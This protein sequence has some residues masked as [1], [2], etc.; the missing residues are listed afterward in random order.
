MTENIVHLVLARTPDA[1]EGVKG[2]SLFIVPKFLPR[3]DGTPG[4]RNDIKCVSIEHKLGIHGSPTC[5]LAYGD[6]KGAIGYLVGEENRGLEYMF[7]MMNHARLSVGV[8]GVAVGERAYQHA[9]EYAKTRVQ[10]R[11]I[12][13]KSGDRVT[14]IHHPDVRRMLMSMRSQT[15]AMRALSYFAAATLDKAKHHPDPAER[16]RNQGLLDL[17]TPIVKGWCTEQGVDVASTG[18]QVHGGMGFIEETG[19][20]Q[21]LRDARITTIYEGT[22]GIQAGDL[23]GR[24]VGYEKGATALA[25]IHAMRALDPK[26][27]AGGEGLASIRS[28]L[29]ES[30]DGLEAAT[31]WIVETFPKDPKAVAGVSVPYL[32]LFGTVAGGW[33]MARAALV[34]NEKIKQPD[35]DQDFLNGKLATT[36]FYAEHEL[37]KAIPHAQEVLRGSASVLAL[38]P[39]KF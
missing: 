23:V 29:K 21:Y 16:K 22:T 6:Q 15:E 20:T 11:E 31:R 33:M 12:G 13:Q 38:G 25:A 3:P 7:T 8:E 37:P 18:I 32:K 34:A 19:A 36:R 4:E 30:V 39:D 26:L 24:K 27:A 9:V 35:A 14:I 1:P 10:G 17:L 28:G 2:I 5:V